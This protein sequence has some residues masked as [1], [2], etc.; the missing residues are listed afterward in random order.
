[1]FLL[2]DGRIGWATVERGSDRCRVRACE[3]TRSRIE[4]LDPTGDVAPLLEIDGVVDHVAAPE[5]R[6][7]LLSL[8][9][10]VAVGI[11]A[12][13]VLRMATLGAAE[14]VGAS[15]HLGT[16]EVGK[17]ADIVLLDANPLEDIRSTLSIW[18]VVKGGRV[19][20]PVALQREPH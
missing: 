5:P 8:Q 1:M 2:A 20:C 3:G 14:A 15:E 4:V 17:L 16:L 12:S 18:R 13:A 7:A 11:P 19:F 6:R 9:A 10:F